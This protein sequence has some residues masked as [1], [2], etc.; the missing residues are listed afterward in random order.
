[1]AAKLSKNIEIS[2]KDLQILAIPFLLVIVLI[3]LFFVSYKIIYPRIRQQRSDLATNKR[4]EVV[5]TKKQQV[6][7][8]FSSEASSY[9]G[10]SVVAVPEK[11]A[12]LMIVSQ[13]K[14]LSQSKLLGLSNLEIGSL[15]PDKNGLSKVQIQFDL[16]GDL[17]QSTSFIKDLGGVAP[18]TNVEKIKVAGVS[19]VTKVSVGLN[20]YSAPFPTK[21]PSITEAESDLTQDEKDTLSKI[22]SLIQPAFSEVTPN[23]PQERPNPFQ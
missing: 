15:V 16:E 6:L 23:S 1:M 21:L 17:L 14:N 18:I 10:P 2:K 9:V 4:N 11:N 12:A 13:I 19:D 20:V 3:V 5:L 7:S 22:T 8:S